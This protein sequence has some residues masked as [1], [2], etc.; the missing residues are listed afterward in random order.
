MKCSKY[1]L[2]TE[3]QTFYVII[4]VANMELISIISPTTRLMYTSFT[5]INTEILSHF[6]HSNK[7]IYDFS[8]IQL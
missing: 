1:S 5:T 2:K 4:Q 8:E 6:Q 7:D 3:I